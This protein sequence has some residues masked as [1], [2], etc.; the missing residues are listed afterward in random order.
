M[1]NI[2]QANFNFKEMVNKVLRTEMKTA[3]KSVNNTLTDRDIKKLKSELNP[4]GLA[5]KDK[6]RHIMLD[7]LI[8]RDYKNAMLLFK[9]SMYNTV[10][11]K[12]RDTPI[13]KVLMEA[14]RKQLHVEA[15]DGASYL[16]VMSK[17][18]SEHKA[19]KGVI[20]ELLRSGWIIYVGTIVVGDTNLEFQVYLAG[21]KPIGSKD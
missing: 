19:T 14:L 21:E 20:D 12:M 5:D 18:M 10:W 6:F 2:D 1:L 3:S 17:T 7:Y 13:G 16:P 8:A 4:D 11:I 9:L 15:S